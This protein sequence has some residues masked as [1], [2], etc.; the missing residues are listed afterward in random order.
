MGIQALEFFRQSLTTMD[1]DSWLEQLFITLKKELDSLNTDLRDKGFL[2]L[3][4][5]FTL[6][7][8]ETKPLVEKVVWSAPS[9]KHPISTRMR[10]R[11]LQI[12]WR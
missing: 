3:L 5:G 1:D 11:A 8:A 12:T 2:Y 6:S 10:E 7:T 9:W 4:I